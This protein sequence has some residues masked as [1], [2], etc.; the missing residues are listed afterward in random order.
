MPR[1]DPLDSHWPE[2]VG[3]I[4]E[5]ATFDSPYRIFIIQD[6]YTSIQIQQGI[7]EV[8]RYLQREYG[9]T[10]VCLEGAEGDF[11]E[12]KGVLK[13]NESE[14]LAALVRTGTLT[15]PEV[16]A[17]TSDLPVVCY[18]VERGDLYVKNAAARDQTREC[19]RIVKLLFAELKDYA[20][21][22][23]EAICGAHLLAF[24]HAVTG[25]QSGAIDLGAFVLTWLCPYIEQAR[26]PI[27]EFPNLML[28]VSCLKLET[29]NDLQ[30]VR[31]ETGRLLNDIMTIL[32]APRVDRGLF[33]R[34]IRAQRKLAGREP[35]ELKGAVG[36]AHMTE[37]RLFVRGV[38]RRL[39]RLG[40][41]IRQGQLPTSE[42]YKEMIDLAILC[43]LDLRRYPNMLRYAHLLYLSA[44]INRM[45]LFAEFSQ[46]IRLVRREICTE[47]EDAV[48]KA[49]QAIVGT[50]QICQLRATAEEVELLVAEFGHLSIKDLLRYIEE[51]KRQVAEA[52]DLSAKNVPRHLQ[53][54]PALSVDLEQLLVVADTVETALATVDENEQQ[55]PEALDETFPEE[56]ELAELELLRQVLAADFALQGAYRFY[57][58]A[59]LRGRTLAENTLRAMRERAMVEAALVT[60]GFLTSQILSVLNRLGISYVLIMPPGGVSNSDKDDVQ[61][62][63]RPQ[64]AFLDEIRQRAMNM[65]RQ[66]HD[67]AE[68]G[69]DS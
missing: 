27:D 68:V 35:V 24:E 33:E 51:V 32:D 14:Q 49:N 1:R 8:L 5:T 4:S 19:Y 50:E 53:V 15:A 22:L 58:L 10:L 65:R 66:A 64:S 25:Y 18:G 7:V 37:Y 39:L 2:A 56:Q 20:N 38:S 30:R 46:A 31:P 47:L 9:I 63:E 61:P 69:N 60:G 26:I 55:Q 28:L 43:R 67:S 45:R 57:Q 36:E 59:P 48:L 11:L 12:F 42:I 62:S 23:K 52:G 17:F 41:A 3:T 34:V 16:H 44:T 6:A 29:A 54:R 21:D 13:P 40:Q